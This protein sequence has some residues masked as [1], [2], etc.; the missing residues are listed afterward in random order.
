MW[1]SYASGAHVDEAAPFFNEE[2]FNAVDENC[3]I[4]GDVISNDGTLNVHATAPYD[5]YSTS[6]LK[7]F[8][9]PATRVEY[10][11][12]YNAGTGSRYLTVY[13]FGS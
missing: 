2:W 6:S 10:D 3:I 12:E 11:F 8:Y 9:D 4:E 5:D 7:M 13:K 1:T